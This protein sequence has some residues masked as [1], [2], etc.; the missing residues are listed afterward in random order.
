IHLFLPYEVTNEVCSCGHF[1]YKKI[2]GRTILSSEAIYCPNC[3]HDGTSECLCKYCI[4][5][6]KNALEIRKDKFLIEWD[7]YYNEY[8]N[9][10][11]D[12][13]DLSIYEEVQLVI[14]I[15]QYYDKDIKQFYFQSI[16]GTI[17]YFGQRLLPTE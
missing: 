17:E 1:L 11:I 2:E 3:R 16:K 8:Y 15:H 12:L 10:P 6:R 9:S 5:I 7:A 14:L 13:N 4:E